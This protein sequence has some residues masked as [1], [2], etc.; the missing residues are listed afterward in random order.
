MEENY[1]KLVDIAY[2]MHTS[3]KFEEAKDVY[4]KLIS[5]NPDDLDVLN[6]YAQLNVSLKNYKLAIELFEKVYEKTQID[7]VLLNIAKVYFNIQDFDNAIKSINKIKEPDIQSLRILAL[8]Y[9]KKNNF[10]DAVNT[11]L[12]I[13]LNNNHSA[14]DLLNLSISY[15]NLNDNDNA[16]KYALIAYNADNTNFDVNMHLSALY[17]EL[18]DNENELKH[19]LNAIKIKPD[20][21]IAYRIGILYKMQKN[22]EMAVDYFNAILDVVPNHKKALQNIAVIYLNHDKKVSAEIFRKIL[23][24]NPDDEQ[25]LTQLYITYKQMLDNE[26]SYKIAKILT[27]KYP[28]DTSY[29]S[30]LGDELIDLCKY[31]EAIEVY[32]RILKTEPENEYANMQIAYIYTHLNRGEEAIEI[33]KRY[34]DPEGVNQDLVYACLREKRLQDVREFFHKYLNKT[35]T[36]ENQEE[37]RSRFIYKLGLNKNYNINEDTLKDVVYKPSKKDLKFAKYKEKS[38]HF[39][40]ITGKRVLVYAGHGVGDTIMFSR[41]LPEVQKMASKV[42]IEI[43]QSCRDLYEYNFPDIKIYSGNDIPNEDE[44]DYSTSFFGLLPNLN[45]DLN[46]LN[47][48]PYLSVKDEWVK[49]KA[50]LECMKNNK[51]KIG[52]FWQ[53][54]PM[55]L[56]NRSIKLE[57][58]APLF[59]IENTQFYSFQISN[60]DTDSAEI[61]NKLPLTDLVPYIKSYADTA[62]FLKNIDVLISIDTSIANLGGAI[63]VKTLLLLP[64]ESEWRWFHDTNKTSWYDSITIFKQT[65]PLIWDDVVERVK[66]ELEL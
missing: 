16:L 55:I 2:N 49:E 65:E 18:N 52:I 66:H 35:K 48:S 13:Y 50:Q 21:E 37:R 4:E 26:N 5:M 25:T 43:P 47:P 51:K 17:K 57:Q 53:G 23:Q 60:F 30:F 34:I 42:I 1:S 11:Y 24:D 61:K 19:L 3:G 27:D 7:E 38:W 63:G 9:I 58:L 15:K 54:N 44:Y 59:D 20:I 56:Q 39:D 45:V 36:K 31:N 40:D 33:F 8:A 12:K 32:K 28:E 62:A 41:Y 6:L 10:S 29:M 64:F 22:D 46:K 14:S